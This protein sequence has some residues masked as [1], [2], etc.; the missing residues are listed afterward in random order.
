MSGGQ[1]HTCGDL[2]IIPRWKRQIKS[3]RAVAVR[4][5][6]IQKAT[7][8]IVKTKQCQ[9]VALEDLNISGMTKNHCLAKSVSDA[10]MRQF[11]TTLEYKQAWVGGEMKLVDR[12]YPSSKTCSTC[13]HVKDKLSLSDRTFVCDSCGSVIDRDLN[14]SINLK[15][16]TEAERPKCANT[17]SSAG[18]YGYGDAKVHELLVA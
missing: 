13:G 14:A 3:R 2:L 9:V 1:D 11:R 12:W 8:D 5:D 16:Y 17:A 10:S 6:G 18:I 7:T 4:K 15:N